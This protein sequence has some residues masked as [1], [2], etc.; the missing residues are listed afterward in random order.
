MCPVHRAGS[1]L[2]F[3]VEAAEKSSKKVRVVSMP[4]WELFEE[5]DESYKNSVLPPD[6]KARV[7]IEVRHRACLPTLMQA[8]GCV[9]CCCGFTGRCVHP[10]V[11]AMCQSSKELQTTADT[12]VVAQAGSTFGWQKY[13]GSDGICIGVDTFGAS[14]PGPVLYKEFGISADAVSAAL[15]KL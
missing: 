9:L 8:P 4:C 12:P 1:E 6:V 11:A 10:C 14:A 3:A 2:A 5:Q 15:D 13:V 7:S